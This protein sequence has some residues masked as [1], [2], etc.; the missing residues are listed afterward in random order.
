M[1]SQLPVAADLGRGPEWFMSSGEGMCMST[2]CPFSFML[3]TH[4]DRCRA[5]EECVALK[6]LVFLASTWL[7]TVPQCTTGSCVVTGWCIRTDTPSYSVLKEC[8][9]DTSCILSK[10]S[11]D[12]MFNQLITQRVCVTH[13]GSLHRA[14]H[15]F[16]CLQLIK[17]YIININIELEKLF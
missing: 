13:F 2:T 5:A 3:S 8:S 10:L 4:G 15:I 12:P 14:T 7:W 17:N 11:I 9:T 16:L 1:F 6:E